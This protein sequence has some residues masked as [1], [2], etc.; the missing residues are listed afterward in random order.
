MRRKAEGGL[1]LLC[2]GRYQSPTSC[3]IPLPT[4]SLRRRSALQKAAKLAQNPQ[5]MHTVVLACFFFALGWLVAHSTCLECE[6]LVRSC[7]LP[8]TRGAAGHRAG[9]SC[10]HPC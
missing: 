5:C 2:T 4:R 9:S 6:A 1:G 3:K 8:R 10:F 7:L